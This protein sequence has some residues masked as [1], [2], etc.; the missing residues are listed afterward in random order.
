MGCDCHFA[1]SAL[2]FR[3][4]KSFGLS[5]AQLFELKQSFQHY[6]KQHYPEISKSFPTHG[7]GTSI[8]YAQWNR[9]Q[10]EHIFT[11]VQ[12]CFADARSQQVFI[13]RLA[14][15]QLFHYERNGKITG[16]EHDGKKA[17]M[18]FRSCLAYLE[19]NP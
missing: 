4:G 1:V 12:Q 15:R 18:V 17:A 19:V 8:S 3:T 5:K 11:A 9:E 13:A 10:R 6:H 7:K 14:E 16:I 2:H